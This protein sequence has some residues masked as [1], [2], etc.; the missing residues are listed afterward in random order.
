MGPSLGGSCLYYKREIE[1]RDQP[2]I[3]SGPLTKS[4][5]LLKWSIPQYYFGKSHALKKINLASHYSGFEIHFIKASFG[6][7]GSFQKS[8]FINFHST[9]FILSLM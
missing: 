4:T 5:C 3:V 9:S 2:L 1:Q 6:W 8:V 7:E